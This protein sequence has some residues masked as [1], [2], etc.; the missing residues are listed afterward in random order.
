MNKTSLLAAFATRSMFG[1]NAYYTGVVQSIEH[2]SGSGNAW[3][4]RLVGFEKDFSVFVRF[5]PDNGN[6][7]AWHGRTEK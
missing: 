4:V 6:I 2:E 7:V 3:N 1:F 5:N